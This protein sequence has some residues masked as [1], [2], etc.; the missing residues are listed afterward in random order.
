MESLLY[1]AFNKI[2]NTKVV[3]YDEK[4]LKMLMDNIY[5][6]SYAFFL[7]ISIWNLMTCS[8]TPTSEDILMEELIE[9]KESRDS[10]SSLLSASRTSKETSKKYQNPK[11]KQSGK[12]GESAKAK[13]PR[14]PRTPH[15]TRTNEPAFDPQRGR[16]PVNKIERIARGEK[17]DKD[18]YPTFDDAPS[19]WD[20]EKKERLKPRQPV[21]NAKEKAIAMGAKRDQSAYPTM[22]DIPSDWE[23]KESRI[24]I[25]PKKRAAKNVAKKGGKRK[26]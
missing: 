1:Y 15:R 10:S 12:K 6:F 24:E 14:Q 17:K 9:E 22:D 25:G 13:Q 16:T 20:D 18:A 11:K 3:L 4:M 8:R 26:K 19:D 23:T 5:S 21:L 2:K 7:L